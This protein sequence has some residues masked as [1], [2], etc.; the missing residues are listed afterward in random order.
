MWSYSDEPTLGGKHHRM[1]N[2]AD[3]VKKWMTCEELWDKNQRAR[4][5][6]EQ[7][8]CCPAGLGL[9]RISCSLVLS[10]CVCVCLRE[11]ECLLALAGRPSGQEQ[12]LHPHTQTPPV[13]CVYLCFVSF[14][15]CLSVYI[16]GHVN[17]Q[18]ALPLY[19]LLLFFLPAALS[20]YLASCLN[21]AGYSADKE[22][23]VVLHPTIYSW[24]EKVFIYCFP[25]DITPPHLFCI[26]YLV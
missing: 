18:F 25:H 13:E 10:V 15:L 24:I 21:S 9:I 12:M 26:R 23:G 14:F 17:A 7:P 20:S 19:T 22:S 3:G 2:S 11:C 6:L 5:R 1:Y 16:V 4:D 8:S